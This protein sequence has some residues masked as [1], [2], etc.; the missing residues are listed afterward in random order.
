MLKLL[1]ANPDTKLTQIY[2]QRMQGHFLV[3]SVHD[4]LSALRSIKIHRPAI[5][6]SE[7]HLPLLSGLA[8]LRFVRTNQN[9]TGMPFIFL[10]NHDDNTEALSFG[11]NDWLETKSSHPDFLLDRIYHHLKTN[12]HALQVH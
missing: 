9:M 5:I 2:N 12:K 1:F 7:Y 6:V 10:S 8:L 3:D 4:G 11:A